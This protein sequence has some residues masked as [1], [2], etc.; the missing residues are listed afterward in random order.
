V[1]TRVGQRAAERMTWSLLAH[2]G[3]TDTAAK[4]DEEYVTIACRLGVDHSWRVAISAAV[5]K[6]L[7][8]SGLADLAR[9]TRAL[10]SA[11]E[12]ALD[13]TRKAAV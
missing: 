5:A 10:E 2:L 4:S 1:V 12:R 7:P 13:A 11:Y 3:V 6:A 8:R 9:Y